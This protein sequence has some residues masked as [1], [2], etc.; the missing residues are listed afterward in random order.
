[1]GHAYGA[2]HASLWQTSDGNPVSA[3]GKIV[4]YNDTYDLMGAATGYTQPYVD[5]DPWAKYLRAR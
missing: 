4:E 3:T 2:R 5:F 1:M